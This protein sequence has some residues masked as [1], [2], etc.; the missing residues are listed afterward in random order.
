MK[1]RLR[2]GAQRTG[3]EEEPPLLLRAIRGYLGPNSIQRDDDVLERM[4]YAIVAPS[5]EGKTQSAFA[6][7]KIRPLYFLLFKQ[8]LSATTAIQ[9]IY[10][11]F[12]SLSDRFM[13]FAV[14]DFARLNEMNQNRFVSLSVYELVSADALI[15]DHGDFKFL[16]LGFLVALMKH[17]NENFENSGKLWMDFFA[18][19]PRSFAINPMSINEVRKLDI[20]NYI[21]FFDE[22][23]ALDWTGFVRNLARA[24]WIPLFVANT[25]TNAANLVG[26]VQ[27]AF[28]R[29]DGDFAWSLVSIRLNAMYMR[30]FSGIN[31]QVLGKI[32]QLEDYSGTEKDLVIGFFNDFL[33]NQ[34]QHLRPGFAECIGKVI[35]NIKMIEA[36][37]ITLNYILRQIVNTLA[38]ELR[39]KKPNMISNPEAVLGTLALFMSN[40]YLSQDNSELTHIFHRKIYLQDHFYYLVNPVDNKKWGFLS[41]PPAPISAGRNVSSTDRPLTVVRDNG[42]KSDWA[43]EYTYFKSE[44]IVPMF[45]FLAVLDEGSIVA[46]FRK[47][48]AKLKVSP[49][50]TGDTENMAQ[51][52]A[53]N[54]NELEVLATVCLI[55][56]SHHGIGQKGATFCG[57]DG[58]SFLTNLVENLILAEGFRRTNKVVIDFH[59]RTFDLLLKSIHVPYL[60][61][62]G[63]KLPEFFKNYLSGVQGFDNRSV[64]FGEYHRTI[65][66][67][68]I[69]SIFQYFIKKEHQYATPSVAKCAVECKNWADNLLVDDLEKIIEKAQNNS[70]S[71]S[72]IVC[73]SI[74]GAREETISSFT[75]KCT[76]KGWNV[77][78][79]T[80]VSSTGSGTKRFRLEQY[81]QGCAFTANPV[82]SCMVLELECINS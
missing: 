57:Q 14:I 6:F 25:N 74:G 56:S 65:N 21:L 47:S 41:Y 75:R 5:M 24:A 4:F 16:L 64:H 71:L 22:F 53:L 40:A 19:S 66:A 36:G 39:R 37:S 69:D 15:K 59:A 42:I 35:V 28:S 34:L 31:D 82:L 70:A 46:H 23:E 48:M 38:L 8:S 76:L 13:Q 72:L 79:L 50:G 63:M 30:I 78:K 81:C 2:T 29:V 43:V 17:A 3:T 54:G 62:A 73:N 12:A 55:E 26:R 7:R 10:L 49:Y 33:N 68:E 67:D 52:V 45:A 77:L 9:D 11:N 51:A 61:P 27:S 58:I 60:F 20:G 80:K 1:E 32:H 18:T 44:E